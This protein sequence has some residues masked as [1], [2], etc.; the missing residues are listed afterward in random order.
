MGPKLA[1]GSISKP[2]REQRY[3]SILKKRADNNNSI[4]KKS[5]KERTVRHVEVDDI[6]DEIDNLNLN[7]DNQGNMAAPADFMNGLD[8]DVQDQINQLIAQRVADANRIVKVTNVNANIPIPFYNSKTMTSATYFKKCRSY[9]TAQGYEP[10]QFHDL[11]PMIMKGEFKLWFDSISHGV[12]SWD[13]FTNKF[14][15][16]YDNESVQNE[17]RRILY[18]RKQRMSDPTEHFIYEMV[19]L[20]KQIDPDESEE[21]CLKRAR[22]AL[23]PE[24]AKFV[25][26]LSEWTLDKLLERV[27]AVHDMIERD[28]RMKK[29]ESRIEI[30]PLKFI[31]RDDKGFSNQSSRGSY[32]Q[33]GRGQYNNMGNRNDYQ[34]Q[35]Y[36]QNYNNYNSNRGGNNSGNREDNNSYRGRN[37]NDNSNGYS[38]GNRGDFNGNRGHNRGRGNFS[39][40]EGNQ[41]QTDKSRVK[42]RVCQEFGHF[43]RECNQ[44]GSL[45]MAHFSGEQGQ[46]QSIAARDYERWRER[47]ENNSNNNG[48]SSRVYENSNFNGNRSNQDLNEER[49]SYGP[50]NRG[51]SRR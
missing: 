43:A 28:N 39:R 31:K 18:S 50:S 38:R 10:A 46:G 6:V 13:D 47:N 1:R 25:G 17:R 14:R 45:T 4:Q 16:R 33:R 41:G 34:N 8:Q 44:R 32:H 2:S 42:C 12:N 3:Q 36:S 24:I 21:S 29:K 5:R 48:N 15:S 26:E 11:L 37:G 7:L 9:L 35:N 27:D 22:D 40:G 30:P 19:N 20:G 51:S 23:I 49:G